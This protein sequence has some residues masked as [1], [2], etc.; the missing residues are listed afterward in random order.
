MAK[1]KTKIKVEKVDGLAPENIARIR[2]AIR[3]VWSWS[4]PRKLCLKRALREDG[5]SVC[6]LCNNV[7]AKV[8]IDHIV[9]VGDVDGGFIERLFCPS[10]GLQALCKK[11][12]DVKTNGER[13]VARIKQKQLKE[14]EIEDFF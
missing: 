2:V 6:E 9:N 7:A 14:K 10:S 1:K 5:F 11:C 13:K 12:H 3:Q 4:W 8:Y